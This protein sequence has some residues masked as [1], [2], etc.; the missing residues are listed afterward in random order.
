MSPIHNYCTEYCLLLLFCGNILDSSI[1]TESLPQRKSLVTLVTRCPNWSVK[2]KKF[3]LVVWQTFYVTMFPQNYATSFSGLFRFTLFSLRFYAL[4][5]EAEETVYALGQNFE[6][7]QV[8]L[9]LFF[10]LSMIF[11]VSYLLLFVLFVVIHQSLI[12]L[13]STPKRSLTYL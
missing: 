8:L 2:K 7:I 6:E 3:T 10:R 1:S 4:S 12:L 11:K 9:K 5:P 13:R